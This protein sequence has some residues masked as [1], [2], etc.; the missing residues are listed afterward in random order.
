MIGMFYCSYNMIWPYIE[1][2]CNMHPKFH[3]P[4]FMV[5]NLSFCVSEINVKIA[6]TFC[7]LLKKI[8]F[9]YQISIILNIT[10]KKPILKNI[11]N[12]T[13]MK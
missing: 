8:H 6:V 7:N 12:N 10:R 5:N 2:K 4:S 11:R 13:R 9:I 1:L 3:D